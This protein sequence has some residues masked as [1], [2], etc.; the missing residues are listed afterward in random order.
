MVDM[1][2]LLFGVTRDIVGASSISMPESSTAQLRTVRDLTTHLCEA[3]PELN[4][5]SSLAVAVNNTYADE[6]EP[7]SSYDE[8]A[9]IPPVSGG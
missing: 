6:N 3:Y 5:L 9:L 8:I 1:T 4:K 7:I 2:I